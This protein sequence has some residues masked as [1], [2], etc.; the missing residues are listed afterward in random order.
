MTVRTAPCE[1]PLLGCDLSDVADVDVRAALETWATSYLWRWT[2]Y[3]FGLC[4]TVIRPARDDCPDTTYAG[5]GAFGFMPVLVGGVWRNLSC[6]LCGTSCGCDGDLT[7]IRLPG[8]VESVASVTIDGDVLDPAA[9]RVDDHGILTRHD[10]DGW[11]RCQDLTLPA[12]A[13]G[14]W[15]VA[16]TWGVPVPVDG[17][18]AAG[19]LACQLAKAHRGDDDCQ[20][21]ERVQTITRQGV[22]V[23]LLDPFDGL[24][25]GR[26]GIWSVDAWVQSIVGSPTRSRVLS[27]DRARSARTTYQ[28]P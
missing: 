15:S 17:Q 27:P 23:G 7:A 3:T 24:H 26:T 8:P 4:E 16:Y 10:G 1:W 21:P 12:D 28:G 25:D 5:A 18:L 6:G 9:Y 2:G 14:T 11:P 13:E 20:L 19:T 22:T